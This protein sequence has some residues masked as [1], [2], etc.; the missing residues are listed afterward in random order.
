[1]TVRAASI[2]SAPLRLAFV[3]WSGEIGGAETFAVAL[4]R[5]LR[6][7][8]VDAR[9]VFVRS[10]EPLGRE[11]LEAGIP[12]EEL[13]LKRGRATLWHARR[14]G[15]TVAAAGA[16]GAVLGAGGFLA[17]ALRI[18]GYRG[19]IAAVE[20]GAVLQLDR[21]PAPA[22][23]LRE[24]DRLSGARAVDVHVAVSDFL[25]ERVKDGPRPVVT[26]PNGVDLDVYGPS[27]SRRSGDGFVVGCMSRLIPGKGVEDVIAATQQLKPRGARL[28]IAGS[29]PERSRLERL[30]KDLGVQESIEFLGWVQGP[31]EVAAFWNQCDVAVSAPNDWVESFGLA[32]VEAMACGR[33]VVA[34]RDGALPE[35][36]VHGRTGFVVEPRDIQALATALLSYLDDAALRAAHGAAAREWCEERFDLQRCADAYAALFQPASAARRGGLHLTTESRSPAG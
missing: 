22:R 4:T 7:L 21:M 33:P 15:R 36:V 20:H 10:A 35:T 12:F 3:L 9:V 2:G 31:R 25:R 30:A 18:G 24:I 6:G 23:L 19:R 27:T 8:G 1:M 32:A 14:F 16:D 29:G 5:A 28:R 17:L 11:F 13:R 26:I 34:T